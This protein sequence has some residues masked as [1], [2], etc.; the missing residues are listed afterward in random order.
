MARGSCLCRE[1]GFE[2]AEPI[3]AV[4]LCHCHKCQKAYGAPFAATLYA[5]REA[6]RWLHGEALVATWDAPLEDSPPAYRHSFCRR[7]GS[8]LPLLWDDLPI[9]EL[10]VVTLDEPV[11]ARPAYRMFTD[12][13]V[14]WVDEAHRLRGYERGAPLREK[15]FQSLR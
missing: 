7:C 3:T 14:D 8:P 4:E 2:V 1:V 5:R 6:F 13:R 12:Q 10:P 9:V 15:V 11:S